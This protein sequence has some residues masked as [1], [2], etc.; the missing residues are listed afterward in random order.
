MLALHGSNGPSCCKTT[1]KFLAGYR[2]DQWYRPPPLVSPAMVLFTWI[3]NRTDIIIFVN[4]D[5]NSS[6]TSAEDELKEMAMKPEKSYIIWFRQR[7]GSTLLCKF[8]EGTHRAGHPGEWLGEYYLNHDLFSL[9]NCRDLIELQN[10]FWST[11]TT[12]NGVLGIKI[13]FVDNHLKEMLSN[14][15]KSIGDHR[16]TDYQLWELLFPKC[17][18]IYMTRRNKI[19]LAV[20]WW[21]AIQTNQWHRLI[22]EKSKSE[23]PEEELDKKYNFDAINHLMLEAVLSEAGMQE[24]FRQNNIRPLTIIYEDFINDFENTVKNILDFLAV[25]QSGLSIGKPYY[26]RLADDLSEK[27]SKRFAEELQHSWPNKGWVTT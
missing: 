1:D 12:S 20:S 5:Y 18:H 22:N 16:S 14:F 15:R 7:T 4:T 23:M 2:I 13:G 9:H 26:G 17:R 3:G 10:K 6:F 27:W 11:G 25:D 8:L 19:R 21:K 24:F